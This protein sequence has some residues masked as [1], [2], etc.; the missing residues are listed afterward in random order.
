M[1]GNCDNRNICYKKLLIEQNFWKVPFN[2]FKFWTHAC[3]VLHCFNISIL[4]LNSPCMRSCSYLAS[5]SEGDDFLTPTKQKCSLLRRR[6][7]IESSSCPWIPPYGASPDT[8]ELM[9]YHNCQIYVIFQNICMWAYP[10]LKVYDHRGHPRW[11]NTPPSRSLQLRFF[12]I[13]SAMK[14]IIFSIHL[15]FPL[16]GPEVAAAAAATRLLW[17]LSLSRSDLKLSSSISVVSSPWEAK[18]W[19][20]TQL[21]YFCPLKKIENHHQKCV[22]LQIHSQGL[23]QLFLMVSFNFRS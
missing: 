1:K 16:V 20:L 5:W 12:L 23:R 4:L 7:I 15:L 11:T 9:S 6:M 3:N 17:T 22:Y 19:S 2:L 10:R 18:V 13:P 14:L 21:N 8:V